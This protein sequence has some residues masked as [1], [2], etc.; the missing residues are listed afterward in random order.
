MLE[1][2]P[3][4]I[5]DFPSTQLHVRRKRHSSLLIPRYFPGHANAWLFEEQCYSD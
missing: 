1:A 4:R 3:E 2:F 5:G